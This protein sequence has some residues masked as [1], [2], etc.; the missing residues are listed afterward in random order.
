MKKYLYGLKQA[1]RDRY[2]IFDSYLINFG[3]SWR[4]NE[5][6]LY[7]K[8]YQQCSILIFCLYVDDM[9]YTGNL[10]LDDFKTIKKMDRQVQHSMLLLQEVWTLWK[11][12]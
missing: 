7:T 10:K 8:A 5:P 2:N 9:I 3:F 11:W 4:N 6:T 1:P 12:M